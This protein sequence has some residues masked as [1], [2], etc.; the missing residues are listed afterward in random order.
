MR[1][2]SLE[3]RACGIGAEDRDARVAQLVGN[4]RDERGLGAYDHKVDT[5]LTH[6]GKHGRAAHHIDVVDVGRNRSRAAVTRGNEQLIALR[7]LGKRPSDR[8]LSTATAKHQ[9]VHNK[10]FLSGSPNT[11]KE[12]SRAELQSRGLT[13]YAGQTAKTRRSNK[14]QRA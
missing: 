1:L 13:T 4:A 6:E 3:Q 14:S 10:P 12:S 11:S 2:A 5:V 9:N 8:M 7:R